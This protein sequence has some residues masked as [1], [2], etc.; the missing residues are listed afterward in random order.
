MECRTPIDG[1]ASGSPSFFDRHT[2]RVLM[3]AGLS[4]SEVLLYYFLLS[5]GQRQ[6]GRWLLL[7]DAQED[8]AAD[9]MGTSPRTLRRRLS[10]LREI[11]A[12][13]RSQIGAHGVITAVALP[14]ELV[15]DL[16]QNSE[17]RNVLEERFPALYGEAAEEESHREAVQEVYDMK[18]KWSQRAKKSQDSIWNAVASGAEKAKKKREF[19]KTKPD[20]QRMRNGRKSKSASMP[21]EHRAPQLLERLR[22]EVKRNLSVIQPK[23]TKENVSKMRTLRDQYG[24]DTVV[25]VIE[26]VTDSTNWRRVKRECNLQDSQIPTPGILL[27]FAESIFP[28]VVQPTE[29]QRDMKPEDRVSFD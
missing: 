7:V 10:R 17:V 27:G 29:T 3:A 23:E 21:H 9:T 28:M 22:R 1:A 19:N 2:Y 14:S 16:M 26:W 6:E 8:A 4:D 25:Q 24:G 15:A 18:S 20:H 5:G 13:A 12:V 11:G